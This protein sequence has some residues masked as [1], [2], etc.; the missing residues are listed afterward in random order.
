MVPSSHYSPIPGAGLPPR[1]LF[2][3]RWGTLLE[4][5]ENGF[6]KSFSDAK[7][8]SGAIDTLFHACQGGWNVYLVGSSKLYR[9]IGTDPFCD[10][11][12][13]AAAYGTGD[14]VTLAEMR[15]VN[16]GGQAVSVRFQ[17]EIQPAAG[18][19]LVLMDR[20]ADGSLQLP[21]GLENDFAPIPLLTVPAGAPR[22]DYEM[23]CRLSNPMTADVL[24]EQRVP[25]T[26]E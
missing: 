21:S 12:L 13:D 25:F 7:F 15:I 5:P 14:T 1:G 20:G 8:T 6:C 19:P 22:G 9:L 23:V 2:I 24:A 16:L 11:E 4:K 18:P 17:L 3:D 26:L 10:L